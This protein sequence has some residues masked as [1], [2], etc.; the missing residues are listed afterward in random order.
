MCRVSQLRSHCIAMQE[1]NDELLFSVQ[2]KMSELLP[3]DFVLLL[4]ALGQVCVIAGT[5]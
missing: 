2:H 5:G 4:C 3:Y 1:Y